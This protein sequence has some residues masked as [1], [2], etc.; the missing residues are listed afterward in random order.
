MTRGVGVD[1]LATEPTPQTHLTNT[2]QQEASSISNA[3]EIDASISEKVEP[4]MSDANGC[5]HDQNMADEVTPTSNTLQTIPG[6]HRPSTP[7]ALHPNDS[8]HDWIDFDVPDGVTAYNEVMDP[9]SL[10]VTEVT[11]RQYQNL[12]QL[13]AALIWLNSHALTTFHTLPGR[14]THAFT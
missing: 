5:N 1:N 8:S 9:L 2:G 14:S 11:E 7:S 10:I 6:E 12:F 13:H 3:H 4:S